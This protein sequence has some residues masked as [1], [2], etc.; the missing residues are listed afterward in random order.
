MEVSY[1]E[2][3]SFSETLV[4]DRRIGCGITRLEVVKKSETIPISACAIQHR[5]PNL[6][7]LNIHDLDLTREHPFLYRAPLFHSVRELRLHRLQSCQ[8]SQLIRFINAFPSLAEL[9]LDFAFN[10][11]EHHGQILPRSCRSE[12]RALTWLEL[13]L[14][15]GVSRLIDWF[16]VSEP[17][18]AQLKTLILCAV[19]I[20]D[21]EEFASSFKGVERLLDRC[22]NSVEDFILHLEKVP[23]VECVSD[24]G[25]YTL[26]GPVHC[27]YISI[28][29][30]DSFPNLKYLTYGT[31]TKDV[32]LPY[33]IWQLGAIT[34]K[35]NLI[36]VDFDMGLDHKNQPDA[37]LCEKLD[38]LL[39]G[40]KFP[41]LRS[42]RLRRTISPKLFPRLD[43]AWQL[44]VLDQSFWLDPPVTA[45][46]EDSE[47]S[48]E[49]NKENDVEREESGGCIRDIVEGEDDGPDT[50]TMDDEN[51]PLALPESDD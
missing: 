43:A 2:L 44:E 35:S 21:E 6:G 51:L 13:D 36:W 8:L 40:G 18:L 31:A 17:F 10:N 29:E 41:W 42:V 12:M 32:V 15:P 7:Y 38:D 37:E 1:E 46:E 47:V 45:N 30:L 49:G 25:G 4:K 11:L 24:L 26:S 23:M 50:T 16:L 3:T 20:P 48:G 19:D 22:H 27:S 28:V 9:E 5:L 14:K 39:I 34:S 33:A